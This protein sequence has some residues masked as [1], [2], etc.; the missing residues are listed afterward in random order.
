MD[1]IHNIRRMPV[2][3]FVSPDGDSSCT[4]LYSS[5]DRTLSIGVCAVLFTADENIKGDYKC[6]L[7]QLAERRLSSRYCDV[8]VE[9]TDC[10][11]YRVVPISSDTAR[12]TDVAPVEHLVPNTS[13]KFGYGFYERQEASKLQLISSTIATRRGLREHRSYVIEVENV[14]VEIVASGWDWQVQQLPSKD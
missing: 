7:T 8:I 6:D 12:F 4:V 11:A 3:W 5:Q 9:F 14:Y 2:P 1:I 13:Q 10:I